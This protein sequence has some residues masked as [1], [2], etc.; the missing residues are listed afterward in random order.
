MEHNLAKVKTYGNIYGVKFADGQ[1]HPVDSSEMAFKLASRY[2]FRQGFEASKPAI[3]EP[4]MNV[5]VK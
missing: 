2:A 1:D 3:K 4:V 5:S